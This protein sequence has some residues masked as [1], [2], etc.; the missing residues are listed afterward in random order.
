MTT[1]TADGSVAVT[2]EH[3]DGYGIEEGG[4]E[5]SVDPPSL[6]PYV[7][8]AVGGLHASIDELSLFASRLLAGVPEVLRPETFADMTKKHVATNERDSWYGYGIYGV[9]SPR[10]P[11]WTHTGAGHGSTAYFICAPRE[12]F[13]VVAITNAGRYSGWRGVRRAAEEAFL[14]AALF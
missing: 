7:Q 6:D 3:A 10:G 14:G 13:A 11:V 9:D 12:R 2:R 8:R 5:R 1:A 4:R